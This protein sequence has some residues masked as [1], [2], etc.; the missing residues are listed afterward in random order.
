MRQE[1]KRRFKANPVS[2]LVGEPAS[3]RNRYECLLQRLPE[4]RRRARREAAGQILLAAPALRRARAP[5]RIGLA[6]THLRRWPLAVFRL[7]AW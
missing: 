1:G 6:R 5:A 3:P 7:Q 4:T 2:V